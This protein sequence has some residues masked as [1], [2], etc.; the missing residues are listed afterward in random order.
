MTNETED[1]SFED[2]FDALVDEPQSSDDDFFEEEPTEEGE[3]NELREEAQEGEEE[4][5]REVDDPDPEPTLEERLSK[6][7]KDAQLWQH[8]Y[9]SDL[10]RQNAF[11]KRL[12]DQTNTIQQLQNQLK[13][14][15]GGDAMT[16]NEWKALQEDYPDI[17]S[18]F[19]AYVGQLEARHKSEIEGIRRDLQPIQSQ[20][21]E[22]Y[23][24]D[25]FRILEMEHPDYREIAGSDEFKSW[26][27]TQPSNVKDMITSQ[28]AG[29][30]AYLLRTYKNETRPGQQASNELKQRR[31]RQLRQA[32]TV[33]SRGGRGKAN[34]P[35][36]DDFEA[37]FDY[38]A[39]S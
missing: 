38:F 13:R 36:D 22:N 29:D 27:N 18:G 8:K 11:Q 35:P 15:A 20:A 33:P 7:E 21:K 10:G 9:N 39:N 32:Q 17:A 30:A 4:G 2:E 5:L 24:Q 14:S 37:A 26:V 25:Q 34:M 23:V 6:A 19:Q 12:N 3:S 28:Q 31:E 16:P 1:T